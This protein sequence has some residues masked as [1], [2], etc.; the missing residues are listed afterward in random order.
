VMLS[1][2][3]PAHGKGGVQDH[4]WMLARGEV[5]RGHDVALIT[6]PHPGGL[7]HERIDGIDVHHE[8]GAPA[9]LGGPWRHASLARVRA[10][11][12]ARGI[13]VIHSQSFCGLHLA[14]R[15]PGVPVVATLHGTHVDELRTRAG[16]LRESL[17]GAPVAAA[18]FAAQWLLMFARFVREGPMLERCDA[19]I[20]TSREQRAVL[21]RHYGVP[22][23]RLHDVWNGID[24]A[25]FAPRAADPALRAQLGG[26]PIV[27]AVARLYQEKGIQHA[28]RAWPRVLARVPDATLVVVGD[29]PYRG[30]LE[31]LAAAQALNG[32]VR[33]TGAVAFEEL[34]RY[35]AA[36][37]VF[38]NPT[39][40]INGYDLTILQSMSAE[41]PVVVSN[42]GSVPT[43]VTDGVD[44][45]LVPPGDAEALAA[46]VVEALTQ[47]EGA[48][49]LAGAARRTVCARFSLERM[50]DGTLATYEAAI[51]HA[52]PGTR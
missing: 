13:D 31:S 34:P 9:A 30:A 52:R 42:I 24:V 18:R 19:V 25:A 22:P 43:A 8:A 5:G 7:A 50:L 28:L 41:R 40:R 12:A 4:V 3:V 10:I 33:F 29:G 6:G 35:Y 49:T 2:V 15:L 27:L 26:G 20:A 48:A 32:H 36:C 23:G 38:V 16:L 45:L 1:P 44:G 17:P 37:D 51:A 14:G 11:H 21:T 39:V 46:R 47:R